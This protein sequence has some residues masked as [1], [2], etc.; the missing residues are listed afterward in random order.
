MS[1]RTSRPPSYRLH[2]PTGQAVVTLNGRDFYLGRHGSPESRAEYDRLIVEWISNGRRLPAPTSEAGSDLSINELLLAYLC[3]ADGYYVKNGEPTTE[4][5]NIRL[6]IRPLRQHLGQTPAREF[7]PLRLKTVRHA[8]IDSGLCRNEVNRRV[9]LIIRTFK[10]A[11][12]EE[13]VPRPPSSL[14]PP[15]RPGRCSGVRT[16]QACPGYVR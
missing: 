7:G 15:P 13:M 12:G 2:R 9:R 3:H 11:V 14:R 4:P 10:W 5:V 1:V 6:A 16:R 8:M